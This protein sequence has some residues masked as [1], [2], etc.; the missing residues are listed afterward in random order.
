MPNLTL[1][2]RKPLVS[3]TIALMKKLTVESDSWNEAQA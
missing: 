3:H 2:L 1:V